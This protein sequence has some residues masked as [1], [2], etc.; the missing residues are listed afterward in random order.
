MDITPSAV[1]PS[2]ISSLITKFR[3]NFPDKS[4]SALTS[5]F[6]HLITGVN[7]KLSEC[8]GNVIDHQSLNL[9]EFKVTI[10]KNYKDKFS[11]SEIKDIFLFIDT[12]KN[13]RV[14]LEEFVFAVR[15]SLI[16]TSRQ[17]MLMVDSPSMTSTVNYI[18]LFDILYIDASNI[19]SS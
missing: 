4:T 3:K 5:C 10:I 13:G 14:G 7:R 18:Y 11:F 1:P 16:M 19:G 15:V 6:L 2:P 9:I 17:L 8:Q 12:N